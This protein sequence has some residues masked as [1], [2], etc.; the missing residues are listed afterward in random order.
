MLGSFDR[1]RLAIKTSVAAAWHQVN[2]GRC[3]PKR[4]PRLDAYL[5]KLEPQPMTPHQLLSAFKRFQ[6]AGLAVTV[7]RVEEES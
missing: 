3:D 6:K 2:L 1:E 7:S 5:A 4:F